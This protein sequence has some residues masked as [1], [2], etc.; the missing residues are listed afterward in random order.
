MIRLF[1]YW[2]EKDHTLLEK[3][4]DIVQMDKCW[5]VVMRKKYILK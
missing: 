5:T 2:E 3:K 4:S 1:E